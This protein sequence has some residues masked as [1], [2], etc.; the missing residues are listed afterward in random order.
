MSDPTEP[1]E[2]EIAQRIREAGMRARAEADARRNAAPPARMPP[3]R[4]GRKG[5][6]PTRY[7]DWEKKGIISDF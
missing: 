6:E 1:T 3:E 5:P 2:A 4:G 7:G